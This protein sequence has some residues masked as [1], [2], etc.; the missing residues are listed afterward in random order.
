[1]RIPVTVGQY[2]REAR[3]TA[4]YSVHDIATRTRIPATIIK[5][6]ES[7]KFDSSGGT[8]YARGHI[9][10]IA[11][12]INAD[13]DR[14]ITAFEETTGESNRPMIE[15]LEENSATVH[16]NRK[17]TNFKA[18]PKII[19]IAAAI[20]AGIAIIIPTGLALSSKDPHKATSVKSS[21]VKSSS[22]QSR[23]ST[24]VSPAS[25]FPGH[26]VVIAANHGSS[27][28]FVADSTGLQIFSG[29]LRNGSTQTFDPTNGLFI[30]IGNAGA[31]TVSVNGK[32]Q[33]AIGAQGEVK[34]LT[35]APVQTNG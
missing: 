5:D 19:A 14:L 20:V 35:F 2:L 1:M 31:V 15:L 32:D 34:S 25:T 24:V 27:W 4:G 21:S 28:L 30:K 12:V 7:E 9:R 6:L 33:G 18:S 26:G 22:L 29:I 11:K 23:T 10:T 17:S 8:A 13:L 16:R 3:E